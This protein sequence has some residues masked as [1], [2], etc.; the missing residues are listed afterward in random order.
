MTNVTTASG[1]ATFTITQSSLLIEF[2]VV[3]SL[4][5][6]AIF[7]IC[8]LIIPIIYSFLPM[9]KP[10]HLEHLNRKWTSFVIDWM[11]GI[12]REKRWVIYTVSTFAVILGAIGIYQ[13]KI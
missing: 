4:S 6:L 10:R 2:G 7:L 13:M 8:L 9:P 1:F 12:V 5:I 3:A 11:T